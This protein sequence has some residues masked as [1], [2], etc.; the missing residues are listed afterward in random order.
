MEKSD[1]NVFNY[2]EIFNENKLFLY[3]QNINL[4]LKNNLYFNNLT[5]I[6]ELD[7]NLIPSKNYEEYSQ[8]KII[9]ENDLFFNNNQVK[10]DFVK[11]YNKEVLSISNSNN[12]ESY[13]SYIIESYNNN[14]YE[15]VFENYLILQNKEKLLNNEISKLEEKINNAIELR[16]VF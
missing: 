13:I 7:F 3:Q 6:K 10:I 11:K 8:L 1:S 15:K 14:L 12:S 2:K 5:S 9:N 16:E 4:L